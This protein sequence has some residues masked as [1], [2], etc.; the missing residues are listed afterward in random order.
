[1]AHK[2]VL[3]QSEA[4]DKVLRGASQ[5]ADAVRITLGPRS[6]ITP[7]E[8]SPLARMQAVEAAA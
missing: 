4:R 1:M 3:F 8:F 6:T 7:E 2:Q 5:L